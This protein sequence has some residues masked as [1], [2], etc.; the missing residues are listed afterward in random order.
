M[1][2][3]IFDYNSKRLPSIFEAI[4]EQEDTL[5]NHYLP[6]ISTHSRAY[7]NIKNVKKYI[8]G[9]LFLVAME[10]AYDNSDFPSLSKFSKKMVTEGGATD[11]PMNPYQL[12]LSK[13]DYYHI[14]HMLQYAI[15]YLRSNEIP[16]DLDCIKRVV[17]IDDVCN[18]LEQNPTIQRLSDDPKFKPVI[19]SLGGP[20][21]TYWLGG[22]VDT[23]IEVINERRLGSYL[24]EHYIHVITS[25]DSNYRV[26]P[27]IPSELQN[28]LYELVLSKKCK[29]VSRNVVQVNDS[30][31]DI[32][33]TLEKGESLCPLLAFLSNQ[34]EINMRVT[35]YWDGTVVPV[36]SLT[37]DVSEDVFDAVDDLCVEMTYDPK[38][39]NYLKLSGRKYNITILNVMCLQLFKD[40]HE[41]LL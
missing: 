20:A 12:K 30:G 22:L 2:L 13:A 21:Q 33:I 36:E 24:D 31:Y 28:Y 17:D 5:L 39:L 15:Q 29:V 34:T 3:G 37:S 35:N 25:P 7:D 23:P 19:Q 11:T 27:E 40:L 9:V 1:L 14:H 6:T 18:T 8:R 38:I 41:R 26:Y 10:H 32:A 16:I 4:I